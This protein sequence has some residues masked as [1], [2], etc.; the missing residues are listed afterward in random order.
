VTFKITG[1]T[2]EFASESGNADAVITVVVAKGKG[3][4]HGKITIQF[5]NLTA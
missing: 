3:A 4:P 2:G 1:G 5:V